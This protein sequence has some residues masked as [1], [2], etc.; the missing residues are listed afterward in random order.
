MQRKLYFPAMLNARDLGGYPTADGR[1]TRWKSLVRS[2]SPSRL[3]P[4]GIQAVRDYG[5]RTVIDLRFPHEL[6]SHPN[7]FASLNHGLRYMNH[8]LLGESWESWR[9][10]PEQPCAPD[11]ELDYS[12]WYS[13]F[14]DF[15]QPELRQVMQSIADAPEG[16]VLYHCAAG[17]DRTGTVTMLLLS[18]AGVDAAAIAED[19]ALSAINLKEEFDQF[20]S[21][22]DDPAVRAKII[23]EQRCEPEFAHHTLMHLNQH[24]GGT[25]NYLLT[26]GLNNQTITRLKARLV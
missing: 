8:S 7:P 6:A 15:S 18:L 14:L 19:Y 2:D 10:R 11:T 22:Y 3:T 4:E 26:I 17:K 21:Q 9:A 23:K 13:A 20:L 16:D 1:R 24:Y 25:Q 5:I 12:Y